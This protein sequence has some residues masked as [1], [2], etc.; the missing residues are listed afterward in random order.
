[1]LAKKIGLVAMGAVVAIFAIGHV[2]ASTVWAQ[3]WD[4]QT[5]DFAADSH[6]PTV[7]DIS[8]TYSGNIED[9]RKGSGTIS[10]M[11]TQTGN[12]LSGTWNSTGNASGGGKLSGKVNASSDVT[13]TLKLHGKGGCSLNAVGTFENGN[14]ISM[15]YHAVGCHHSDHGTIDM[16]D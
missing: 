2:A 7:P 10:A 11:I 6:P 16:T 8:G 14:Q 4:D 15:V 3:S 13:M 5:A 9:H 1:M 12:V